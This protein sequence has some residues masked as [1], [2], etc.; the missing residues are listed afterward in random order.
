MVLCCKFYNLQINRSCN[1][2]R[3]IWLCT[4]SL[5]DRHSEG[6]VT[7]SIWSQCTEVV[8]RPTSQSVNAT[9]R[10]RGV[11][12]KRVPIHGL[13]RCEVLQ[14]TLALHPGEC[15]NP[16]VTL[17]FHNHVLW[18]T[19]HF[20]EQNKYSM[21]WISRQNNAFQFVF[22]PT[23]GLTSIEGD[24][25]T[26]HAGAVSSRSG[27]ANIINLSAVQVKQGAVVCG[28]SAGADISISTAGCEWVWLSNQRRWPCYRHAVWVTHWV[29]C[30]ILRSTRCCKRI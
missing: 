5:L 19:G 21:A 8:Q 11:A 27:Y 23:C 3:H 13:S 14:R 25:L 10:A 16:G 29:H 26:G 17:H 4:C 30:Y 6:A 12:V 9:G 15:S 20:V 2:L 1:I 28:A 7:G 18:L 22:K 24:L